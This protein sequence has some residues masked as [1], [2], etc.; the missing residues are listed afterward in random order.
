MHRT[1]GIA[2][3]PDELQ[4]TKPFQ[5]KLAAL[6]DSTQ[7]RPNLGITKANTRP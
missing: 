5:S 3:L 2:A 1:A 4:F 7:H 6:I